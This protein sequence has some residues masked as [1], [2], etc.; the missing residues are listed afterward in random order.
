MRLAESAL[1][2]NRAPV[3]ETQRNVPVRRNL[4]YHCDDEHIDQKYQDH[5]GDMDIPNPSMR[6]EISLSSV[7]GSEVGSRRGPGE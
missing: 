2:R 4:G 6:L 3:F 5:A 1:N 7:E